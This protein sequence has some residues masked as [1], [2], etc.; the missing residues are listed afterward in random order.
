MKIVV[1]CFEDLPRN[2]SYSCGQGDSKDLIRVAAHEVCTSDR[3]SRAVRR[4]DGCGAR[5]GQIG[6]EGGPPALR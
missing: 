1:Y 2:P 3:R 4:T 6:G 5:Q